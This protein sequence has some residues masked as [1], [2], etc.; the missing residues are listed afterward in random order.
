MHTYRSFIFGASAIALAACSL[1]TASTLPNANT[2]GMLPNARQPVADVASSGRATRASIVLQWTSSKSAKRTRVPRF[3]SP[4]AQSIQI[5]AIPVAGHSKTASTIVNRPATGTQSTV[6][7]DV[8]SGSD[9]FAFTVFDEKNAT[10]NPIGG[11]ELVKTMPAGATTRVGVSLDG[12]VAKAT[13]SPIVGG[14]YLKTHLNTTGG[15][16]YTLLGTAPVTFSFTL[17]DADGNVLLPSQSGAQVSIGSS[18]P[19]LI[20]VQRVAGASNRFTIRAMAPNPAFTPVSIDIQVSSGAQGSQLFTQQFAIQEEALLYAVASGSPGSVTIFDQEGKTYTA[21]GG[22]P[23][24]QDP[25]AAEWDSWD[26]I[27]F[28]ADAG[29]H[30]ILA[31]DG[32]GNASSG[33]AAPSVPGI[34]SLTYNHDTHKV[35]ATAEQAAGAPEDAVLAFDRHG[36]S[37][38]TRGFV[39]V[40]GPFSLAYSNWATM[41]E[42]QQPDRFWLLTNLPGGSIAIQCYSTDGA[43]ISFLEN[44]EDVQSVTL[45]G[46]GFTPTAMSAYWPGWPTSG[47]REIG[48]T[49]ADGSLIA[50]TYNGAGAL[51]IG[52]TPITGAGL[53]PAPRAVVQDPLYSWFPAVGNENQPAEFY[54]ANTGG[55]LDAIGAVPPDLNNSFQQITSVSFPPPAGASSFSA[56]AITF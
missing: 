42:P 36:H 49:G 1:S 10:G 31:Y 54:V 24:L 6:T 4:S 52:I 18:V 35:Y 39:G 23:G 25:I 14:E 19:S 3:I 9:D 26:G 40:V 13:L 53:T 43:P 16:G 33:W 12:Y 8:P 41:N 45:T 55:G 29:S 20:A 46:T 56:L 15:A 2:A 47:S 32:E 48:G 37:A 11:A 7:F 38:K 5:A 34:T 50:G 22:F 21:S 28:V 17:M 27:L 44:G 30:T 51:D